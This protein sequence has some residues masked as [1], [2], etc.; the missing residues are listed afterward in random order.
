M[1]VLKRNRG[2]N[3]HLLE[4]RE[5]NGNLVTTREVIESREGMHGN[6][7]VWWGFSDG[8]CRIAWKTKSALYAA[9]SIQIGN[10]LSASQ[11]WEF[12][13]WPTRIHFDSWCVRSSWT[14]FEVTKRTVACPGLEVSYRSQSRLLAASVWNSTGSRFVVARRLS[15]RRVDLMCAIVIVQ[16]LSDRMYCE[17]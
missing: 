12:P 14:A 10:R 3:G 1:F 8:V 11:R 13:F 15:P 4:R 5:R 17:S 16:S 7:L 2:V 6:S 9:T